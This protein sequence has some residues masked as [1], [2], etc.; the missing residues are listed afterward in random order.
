MHRAFPDS[1]YYKGSAPPPGHQQTVCLPATPPV[2]R[3]VRGP[4]GGSRVHLFSI[5]EGGIQLY[6]D[7]PHTYAADNSV[8]AVQHQRN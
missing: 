2:A 3:V 8:W 1:E 7:G 6:P 5:D 4:K